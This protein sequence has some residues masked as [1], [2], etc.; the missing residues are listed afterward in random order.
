MGKLRHRAVKEVGQAHMPVGG[1]ARKQKPGNQ[2]RALL[3]TYR[4]GKAEPHNGFGS[5]AIN[6]NDDKQV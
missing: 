5:T 3:L 4:P 6:L 2:A 1:R